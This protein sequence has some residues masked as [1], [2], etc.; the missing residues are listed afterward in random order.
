MNL[1]KTYKGFI[2]LLIQI[3]EKGNDYNGENFL[4]HDELMIIGSMIA[5]IQNDLG[6]SDYLLKKFNLK[7]NGLT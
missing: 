4:T 3:A 1:P 5:G 7:Y 6:E 2:K